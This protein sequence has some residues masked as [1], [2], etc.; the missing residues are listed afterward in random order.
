MRDGLPLILVVDDDEAV[1]ESLR[2]AL[3]L[4]DLAVSLCAAGAELFT[5]PDLPQAKCVVLDDMM[6]DLDGIAVLQ[7]LAAQQIGVPVVLVAEHATDR[8]R[9]QAARAGARFVIEKPIREGAL[10]AA[11]RMLLRP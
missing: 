7:G 9:Q 11:I 2:F 3:E 6:P 1:R 8:L 10:V 5:H 4:E